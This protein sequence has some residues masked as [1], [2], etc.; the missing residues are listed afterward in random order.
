[1]GQNF[2]ATFM[3]IRGAEADERDTRL[4]LSLSFSLSCFWLALIV[5]RIRGELPWAGYV[6]FKESRKVKVPRV[7]LIAIPLDLSNS[8]VSHLIRLGCNVNN[9]TPQ[10]HTAWPG[11]EMY[12]TIISIMLHIGWWQAN[13]LFCSTSCN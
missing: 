11:P 1:M 12:A 9:A 10:L 4:R 2:L 3:G 13:R 5:P 6:L 7:L 8:I